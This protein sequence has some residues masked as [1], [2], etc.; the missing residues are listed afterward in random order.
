MCLRKFHYCFKIKFYLKKN[1]GFVS[2]L[3]EL[4]NK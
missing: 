3:V 2:L 1:K 4:V